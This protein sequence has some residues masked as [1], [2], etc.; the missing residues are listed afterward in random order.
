MAFAP[1][2]HPPP[3]FRLLK[4]AWREY[5]ASGYAL[6]LTVNNPAG[7]A[8][9]APTT[10]TGTVAADASVPKPIQVSVALSQSGSTKATQVVTPNAAGAFTTTFP[11]NTLVA[12]SAS[13]A[14]SAAYANTVTSNTFTVT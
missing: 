8:H 14:A 10:V 1:A 3:V 5:M 4:Q 2:P 11:A 7:Q 6:V 13:A 12:G 9:T